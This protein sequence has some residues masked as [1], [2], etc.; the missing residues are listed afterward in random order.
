MPGLRGQIL[1]SRENR[2]KVP[3]SSRKGGRVYPA[4]EDIIGGI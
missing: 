1:V 2:E 4:I 3:L